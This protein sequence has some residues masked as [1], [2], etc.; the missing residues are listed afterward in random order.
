MN[1]KDSTEAQRLLLGIG[2]ETKRFFDGGRG[3]VVR[4]TGE[5]VNASAHPV[6]ARGQAFDRG[7][8][9]RR[10]VRQVRPAKRN[11]RRRAAVNLKGDR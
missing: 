4:V 10:F 5:D 11:V 3:Y 8:E 1:L 7:E 2:L 6:P 9:V